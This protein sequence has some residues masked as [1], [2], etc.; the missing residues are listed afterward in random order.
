[1]H[2]VN[3]PAP[4]E[5]NDAEPDRQGDVFDD[6]D[7]ATALAEQ[8]ALITRHT[9]PAALATP[10]APA[11]TETPLPTGE[12]EPT[13][14]PE[15]GPETD[16]GAAGPDTDDTAEVV[17]DLAAL[18]TSTTG[19]HTESADATGDTGPTAINWDDSALIV[20][21]A[22]SPRSNADADSDA[23]KSDRDA[24]ERPEEAGRALFTP[25]LPEADQPPL[26]TAEGDAAGLIPA[27]SRRT[28]AQQLS[29][30]D[31]VS[32]FVFN[33]GSTIGSAATPGS[34]GAGVAVPTGA[35]IGAQGNVPVAAHSTGRLAKGPADPRDN[36]P[37]FTPPAPANEADDSE[38]HADGDVTAAVTPTAGAVL[39]VPAVETLEA[40]AAADPDANTA[41]A[42]ARSRRQFI[43][44]A[45]IEPTADDRRVASSA[46]MFW[47]WFATGAS[48]FSVAF[49]GAFFSLGMSLRQSIVSI[50][51]GIVLSFLPLAV[52]T[53]AGKRSGASSTVISRA[54]FGI[55]GNILPAILALLNR[56]FWGAAFLWI[57]GRAA[58]GILGDAGIT[59]GIGETPLALV[60]MAAALVF[61]VL[62]ATIGYGAI[63]WL[64]RILTVLTAVLVVGFI[65]L[66]AN[67][68]NIDQA[69]TV[70][71]GSWLLVITGA[72]LVFSFVGLAWANSTAD[73][74][75]YQRPG[76]SGAAALGFSI[77]GAAVPS[78]ILIG[79]GAILAA[80]DPR[81]AAGFSN[82]PIG[83][84]TGLL[85]G[86]YPWVVLAA[87]GLSLVS[88]VVVSVW[89]AG[90]ALQSSGARL[91]RPVAVIVAGFALAIL[92]GVF[93]LFSIDF[94]ALF[95]DVATTLAVPV[96]AWLGIFVSD[97]LIRR[98]RLHTP[99]LLG[100]GG[101]YPTVR[102]VN[103]IMLVV[104]TV[105]GLGLVTATADGL[106][107]VGYLFPLLD[108]PT[109]GLLA[110]T[111]TGVIVAL[112]L[113]LLTPIVAG[114]PVA[115]RQDRAALQLATPQSEPRQDGEQVVVAQR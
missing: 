2:P 51:A 39:S 79:Y 64:Q 52:G 54:T 26:D 83:T 33:E 109:T 86:G 96:A 4:H 107:W 88:G 9:T 87:A 71:D 46:R 19:E 53:V 41:P 3:S 74:A 70:P 62:V 27:F 47:L 73:L 95:R 14:A 113:G 81:L 35:A 7:I 93:T 111:D 8:F 92:A 40:A 85:P 13:P 110:N 1:M 42:V 97:M 11:A 82:E 101:I 103:V 108:I 5:H 112:L 75:R 63:L 98:Q 57:L 45:G 28:S 50:L 12:I 34:A 20:P 89:S 18:E 102:P 37:R 58:S 100:R 66:T 68:I 17:I 56:L 32:G 65:V 60:A 94:T 10:A 80:S 77:L 22:P 38:R 105:V 76:S 115:R 30:A 91:P 67:R 23:G 106:G 90:F 49:G 44:S 59:F 104:S 61:S 31:L 55:S 69:I 6:D 43:E 48:L 24:A 78:G 72:V 114:I 25:P 29:F 21:F 99:S 15:T 36:I 84:L 16:P